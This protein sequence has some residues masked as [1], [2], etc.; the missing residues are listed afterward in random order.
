MIEKVKLSDFKIVPDINS[1]RKEEIDDETY[2]SSK[3]AHYISNSRLKWIEPSVNKGDPS[4]F[5]KPPVLKTSSLKIG[6]TVHELLLQPNEFEMAPKL[7]KP[8]EKLG[9]V[10]DCI[11]RLINDDIK[12]ED[13]IRMACVEVNY[14][15]NCIDS[16]ID[17]IKNVWNTYYNNL[18]RLPET[19]KIRR[20][21]S[22]KDWDVVNNCVESCKN[23]DEIWNKLH[24]MDT[25]GN[26][27][28]T[29]FEEAFFIDYYVIYKN[30][31]CAKLSFKMKA[32]NWTIDFNNKLL[33]LND[34]KTT[35]HS[36]NG[37][38]SEDGSWNKFSYARQMAVYSEILM[39]YCMKNFGVSRKMGW[40]LENNML[41]VETIPHYWSRCYKV[42]Y[43]QLTSGK[44][45]LRELLSRVAYCE[46][47]GYD[48][49]IEFI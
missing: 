48:K 31:Y 25:L 8:S 36:V 41:V 2:F 39:F 12:L 5:L 43:N 34:L 17:M 44:H 29:H 22:D 15:V 16:K 21:V 32:D 18:K 11:E 27:I 30:K 4:I 47:F 14:F 45:M 33:T 23:N 40:K 7:G 38:M 28:E 20:I 24:P 35:G 19:D 10:L 9:A 3:Y 46:L 42:N 1:V 26:P 13:A 49:E 6:S 37:F